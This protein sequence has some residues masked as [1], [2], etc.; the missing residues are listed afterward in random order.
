MEIAISII[1]ACVLICCLSPAAAFAQQA[2]QADTLSPEDLG[3]KKYVFQSKAPKGSVVVFRTDQYENDRLIYRF[4]SISNTPSEKDTE[5]VVFIDWT[6]IRGTRAY[7]LITNGGN[8]EPPPGLAM[9]TINFSVHPAMFK[10][11]FDNLQYNP[12][13]EPKTAMTYVYAM[14]N[15]RYEDVRRRVPELPQLSSNAWTYALV[16]PIAQPQ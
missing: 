4:E 8:G 14:A 11:V 10:I 7:A 13:K 3:A 12:Q 1:K 16:Y 6:R 9:H 2:R 5:K 15:E